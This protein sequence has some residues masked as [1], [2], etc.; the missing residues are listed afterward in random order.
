MY[1]IDTI[2]EIYV[3]CLVF[4]QSPTLLHVNGCNISCSVDVNNMF[5]T[6][7]CYQYIEGCRVVLQCL[8]DDSNFF[9]ESSK[10]KTIFND[11][12]VPGEAYYTQLTLLCQRYFHIRIGDKK[13][14][15]NTY[16]LARARQVCTIKD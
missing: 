2:T 14:D 9:R 5:S 13:K 12:F 6:T 11:I 3:S 8:A 1:A 7:G 16:G 10:L 4:S 15:Q